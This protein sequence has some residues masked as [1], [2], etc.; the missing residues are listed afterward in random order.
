MDGKLQY[1]VYYT[2][3]KVEEIKS[4]MGHF[5]K[6]LLLIGEFNEAIDNVLESLKDIKQ[7]E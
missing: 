3:A 5:N 6:G 7:P 4:L 1:E 2:R